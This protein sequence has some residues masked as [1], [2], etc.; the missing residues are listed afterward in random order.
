MRGEFD[1]PFAADVDARAD[2]VLG[3]EHKLVVPDTAA[4]AR[5]AVAAVLRHMRAPP[6]CDTWR[7][8]SI[9]TRGRWHRIATR[10]A[11]TTLRHVAM[12]AYNTHSG[13]WSRQLDGCI[14]TTWL[15]LTVR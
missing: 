11:G 2:V 9:A 5:A 3:R 10:G 1:K 6:Q 4:R 12:G 14:A 13:L 15:S 7:W 8:H